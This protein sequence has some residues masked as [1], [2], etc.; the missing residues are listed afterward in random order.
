MRGDNAANTPMQ[1]RPDRQPDRNPTTQG[2]GSYGTGE[3]AMGK[4]P[5]S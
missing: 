5:V 4:G 2:R 1:Y 3:G